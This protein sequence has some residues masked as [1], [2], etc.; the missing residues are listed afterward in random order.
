MKTLVNTPDKSTEAI[1]IATVIAAR[2]AQFKVVDFIKM[3]AA[4][5]LCGIA[6]SLCAV[7]L[8]LTLVKTADV[9]QPSSAS[10]NVEATNGLDS[11][12]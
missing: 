9:G 12:Q 2:R 7:A 11:N 4:A 1:A 5:A 3:L 6:F 10:I 8:T